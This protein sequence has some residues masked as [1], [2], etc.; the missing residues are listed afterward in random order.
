[1][2]TRLPLWTMVLKWEFGCNRR[3]VVLCRARW[4][5]LGMT[6]TAGN[7]SAKV[8]VPSLFAGKA[9][10]QVLERDGRADGQ[11]FYAVEDH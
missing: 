1:M 2:G 7:T 9:W 3:S 8:E 4:K 11:F 5:I 6:M 10:Q